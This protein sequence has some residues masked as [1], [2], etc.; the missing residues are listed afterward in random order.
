LL[1]QRREGFF[2]KLTRRRLEDGVICSLFARQQATKAFLDTHDAK[3]RPFIWSADPTAVVAVA[4]R[5]RQVL[6]K[7]H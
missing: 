2:A 3:P 6:E 1:A 5:R 7:I 4:K